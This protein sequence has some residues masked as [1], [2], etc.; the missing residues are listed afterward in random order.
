MGDLIPFMRKKRRLDWIEGVTPRK[1][2]PS[3]WRIPPALPG[4]LVSLPKR[5]APLWQKLR[6]SAA[7]PVTPNPVA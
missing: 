6:G 3:R 2:K 5:L 7:Q 4:G 1:K